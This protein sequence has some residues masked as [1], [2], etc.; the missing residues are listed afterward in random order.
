M[1]ASMRKVTRQS[2]GTRRPGA[3]A[4]CCKIIDKI[5]KE[6]E[7]VREIERE[8]EERREIEQMNPS[9]RMTVKLSR[10]SLSAAALEE[11]VS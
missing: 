6:R 2:C 10:T 7:K 1:S 5:E 3:T 4:D 11:G 8:P 9:N